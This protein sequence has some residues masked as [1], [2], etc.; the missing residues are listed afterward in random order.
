M[1]ISYIEGLKPP[2]F[3]VLH[4]RDGVSKSPIRSHAWPFL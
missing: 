2:W 3:H 1:A 4:N